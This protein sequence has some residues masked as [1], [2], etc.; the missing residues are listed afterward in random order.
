MQLLCTG[1]LV[2][3]LLLVLGFN[4]FFFSACFRVNPAVLVWNTPPS[5][6]DEGLRLTP[7]CRHVLATLLRPRLHPRP[8]RPP[9]LRSWSR[10]T[11]FVKRH[12]TTLRHLPALGVAGGIDRSHRSIDLSLALDLDL[13]LVLAVRGL[14][15]PSVRPGESREPPMAGAFKCRIGGSL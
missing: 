8:L 7:R 15:I 6:S 1:Q 5:T 9:P 10:S 3:A 11:G 13:V 4:G 2:S 14:Y 12:A